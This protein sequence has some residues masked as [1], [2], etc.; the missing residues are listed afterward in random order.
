MKKWITFILLLVVLSCFSFKGID[1]NRQQNYWLLIQGKWY[2]SSEEPKDLITI[3]VRYGSR[4]SE[5][6]FISKD[7]CLFKKITPADKYIYK[8][9]SWKPA[10]DTITFISKTDTMVIKI[11]NLTKEQ[12]RFKPLYPL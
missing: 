11:L 12:L 8:K 6:N 7:T 10:H 2:F 4:S 3:L 1:C 5:I 9:Y